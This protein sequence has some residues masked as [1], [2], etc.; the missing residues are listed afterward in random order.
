MTLLVQRASQRG[1]LPVLPAVRVPSGWRFRSLTGLLACLTAL[2][3]ISV[4]LASCGGGGGGG[5]APPPPVTLLSIAVTPAAPSVPKG[6]TQQFKAT[7]TFTD[8]ST[9]DLTN[10]VSWT[11]GTP[12]VATVSAASGFATSVSVG[13]T[14]VTATSGSVSGSAT[15]NVTPAVVVSALITPN[16]AFSGVGASRQLTA[17]G[18][19][20]DAT[21]ANVTNIATWT[22]SATSVATIGPTT[23]LATGVS[24]GSTTISATIGSV[25][26]T[27][28]L[29][30]VSNTWSPAASL[31]ETRYYHTA[32]LLQDGKVLVVADEVWDGPMGPPTQID[33]STELYDPVTDTWLPAQSVPG[34]RASHTATLLQN[35]KVL[36]AGGLNSF[37]SLRGL[38][39]A[40]LYDPV[41]NTWTTAATMLTGRHDHTATLL[42]NGKVL[43][44][45]GSDYVT[46]FSSAELYDPVANTWT[47]AGTMSTARWGHSATLLNNG[48]VLIAGGYGS[49]SGLS[50]TAELYDPVSNTWSPAG[51]MLTARYEQTTTL[52]QNGK[53]LVAGGC[54][55]SCVT[56]S[57]TELYD[58]V[59]NTWSATAS[60]STP[61]MSHTATIIPNGK[62]LVAGG[63]RGYMGYAVYEASAELYDPAAD[64]WS[65]AGTMSTTREYHT[66]TLLTNGAVI[67]IG[68][69]S[70]NIA[71]FAELYW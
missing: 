63:A 26:A 61:R 10:S 52:L 31:P 15:L 20:S 23:G 56:T 50:A 38:N 2:T 32:T 14:V 58:P 11:S 66:A 16:P 49:A 22:S 65:P 5:G 48:K 7:G 69:F 59:A 55:T 43:V 25:S 30:I 9:A 70:G 42:P 62:V 12:A 67:V 28:P 34:F 54:D 57:S 27:A 33:A 21:M 44:T 19:Y 24:L 8:S 6:L 71:A 53:V 4:L 18:T 35:G 29:T 1:P 47:P 60:M 51:S 68:G 3:S 41:A 17:T 64:N 40:E 37:M 36:V 39:S 46:S 45:G 13:S